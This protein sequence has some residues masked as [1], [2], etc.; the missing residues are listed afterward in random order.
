M[1]QNYQK[2]DKILDL[3]FEYPDN[4]FTIR[5]ISKKVKIPRSTVQRYLLTL[6]EKGLINTNQ[7]YYFKFMKSQFITKKI[8]ESGLID[9]LSKLTPSCIILFGSAQKG[10]YVKESDIDLYIETTNKQE[11]ILTEYEKKIGHKIQLF[12]EPSI[13]KLPENLRNNIINGIKLF[14]YL[15]IK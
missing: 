13:D 12:V 15:K 3:L 9:Y 6:K 2:W 5:E 11:I 7:N 8:I 1:G 14:G 4:E 10:E